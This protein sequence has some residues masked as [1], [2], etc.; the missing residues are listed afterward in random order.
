V[1]KIAGEGGAG[2]ERFS[3]KRET[4]LPQQTRFKIEV[5]LSVRTFYFLI[6]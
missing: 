2:V 4:G 6:N 3:L 1:K 5:F